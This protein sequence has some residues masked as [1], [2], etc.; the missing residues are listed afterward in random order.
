MRP[1]CG[2]LNT[3]G[4]LGVTGRRTSN[5]G[6]KWSTSETVT[7]VLAPSCVSSAV[8]GALGHGRARRSTRPGHKIA[9]SSVVYGLPIVLHGE[10]V[11]KGG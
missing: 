11:G 9:S 3:A 1:L 2:E 6:L 10:Y 5:A 4:A 7:I 8:G